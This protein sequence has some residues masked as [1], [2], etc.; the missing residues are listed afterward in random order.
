MS[1][2]EDQLSELMRLSE[3][4]RTRIAL[5]LLDSLG[6]IDPYE[7]TSPEDFRAEMIR[8]AEEAYE[9]PTDGMDWETARS[10][11]VGSTKK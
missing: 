10:Q 2:A 3:P 1:T 8:R 5:A 9:S 4:E 6:G 7:E 11:I